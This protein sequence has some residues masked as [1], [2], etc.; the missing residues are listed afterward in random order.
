MSN[1]TAPEGKV[2]VCCACGKMSKDRYGRQAITRGW[3]ESCVL[4]S[5]LFDE[6]ALTIVDGRVTEVWGE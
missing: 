5:Q 4:H 2:W 6:K 3:D 1:E